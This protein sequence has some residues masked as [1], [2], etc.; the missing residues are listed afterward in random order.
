M[1]KSRQSVAQKSMITRPAEQAA[2]ARTEQRSQFNI[3]SP[4][5]E[6]RK[7]GQVATR[8]V[9]I[10]W[11]CYECM[12]FDSGGLGSVAAAVRDCPAKKCPLWPWR[13]GPLDQKGLASEVPAPS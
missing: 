2:A 10:R 4:Q 7:P 11:F 12:G 1:S 9:A 13:N 8:S 5:K 3:G 6:R